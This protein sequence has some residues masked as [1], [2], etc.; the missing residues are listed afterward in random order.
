GE[1][2]FNIFVGF[3]FD[4]GDAPDPTYP[5]L[6]ASNGARHVVHLDSSGN[7]DFYLGQTIT[8]ESDAFQSALADGDKNPDGSSS[9]DGIQ[10]PNGLAIGLNNTITITAHI[11]TGSTGF[12]DAWM[13][14]NEDGAWSANEEVITHHALGNG[15]NT[16]T[17]TIPATAQRG[18]AFTRFRLSSA[19]TN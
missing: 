14:L 3:L 17:F 11:P 16:F 10:L 8:E 12:L 1:T 5:T 19:G 15:T 18:L 2:S 9:D 6:L 13:D 4:F 7:P